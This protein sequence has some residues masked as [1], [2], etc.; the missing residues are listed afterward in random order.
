MRYLFSVTYYAPYISGV[1]IYVQRLA[2]ALAQN[3]QVCQV[4][5]YQHSPDLSLT[6]SINGVAVTRIKPDIK[7]SKGFLAIDWFKKATAL[8]KTSEIVIINLP[9]PE[10]VFLSILGKIYGKKVISVYH[11]EIDL[12]PGIV[13]WLLERLILFTTFW[14]FL[15]SN[16]IVTY[17]QDYALASRVV[18]PFLAKT[19]F[20]YPP[21][22]KL[23]P[24]P[25]VNN[26]IFTVG[27]AA[28][29]AAEKGFEYAM[30]ALAG[31]DCKLLVAGPEDPVGE[32]KY[33]QKIKILIAKIK[34]QVVFLGPIKP[35]DMGKFY[36]QIDVLLLPSTN[37]T[38][39]F[40][41]VQVE[42][43]L[44][45]KPVITSDLPGVR[46]PVQKTGMGLVVP[47]KNVQALR[48]AIEEIR[49]HRKT[50]LI[51]PKIVEQE[52]SLN[53]VIR[54]YEQV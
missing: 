9:Q 27:I 29:L 50:Y 1:T 48:T 8:V 47:P 17:T 28:R 41:I 22:V 52:F 32:E 12:P 46:V 14:T 33:R 26:K 31:L 7:I 42:A 15:F 11:C 4:L 3:K 13:N 43:M 39:A 25:K 34:S 6:E 54:F 36:S 2:E 10:G 20:V 45:R 53:Q 21:I 24:G 35:A 18:R 51:S 40:G 38:E 30:A 44:A 49:D 37:S 5:C 23:A 16:Q 19:H